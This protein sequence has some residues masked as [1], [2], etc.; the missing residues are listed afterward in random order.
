M[1]SSDQI[2]FKEDATVLCQVHGSVLR[3]EADVCGTS[4]DPTSSAIHVI[5]M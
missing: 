1:K 2:C 4:C 5:I 3:N